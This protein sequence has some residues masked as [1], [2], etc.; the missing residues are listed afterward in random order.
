MSA[1][2][3]SASHPTGSSRKRNREQN[4]ILQRE[5]AANN[6]LGRRE[7]RRIASGK[8]TQVPVGYASNI[9]AA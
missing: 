4:G 2:M 3:E 6:G 5:K 9:T 8:R 7:R 1:L